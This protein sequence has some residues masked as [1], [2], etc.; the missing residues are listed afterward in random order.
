MVC[1]INPVLMIGYWHPVLVAQIM[2]RFEIASTYA[3]RALF[4]TM[5]DGKLL[6][7]V[8]SGDG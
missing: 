8:S 4:T 1:C 3:A 6:G 5:V 7:E 2:E